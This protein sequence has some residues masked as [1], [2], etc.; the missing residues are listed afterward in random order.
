MIILI[1]S[2]KNKMEERSFYYRYCIIM[3]ISCPKIYQYLEDTLKLYDF[4]VQNF[5]Q[6]KKKYILISQK[7]EQ[8]IL[9][10]AETL[11]IKKPKNKKN[12]ESNNDL[13]ELDQRIIDLEKKEYFKVKDFNEYYPSQSFYDLY[14][15]NNK[16]ESSENNNKRYGLGLFT[17]SEMIYIEK[18]ILENIPI[19]DMKK[20]DELL[21][22]E[23]K[24]DSFIK[25]ILTQELH[26]NLKKKTKKPLIEENSL[27]N[28]LI[29]YK[30]I[31]DHFPLHISNISH[32]LNKKFFS[33]KIPHKLIQNY[34]NDEVAIYFY[35]VDHYT[36]F[37]AIPAILSLF[38]FLFSKFL[39]NKNAE[40]LHIFYAL[41][42]TIWAQFFIIFWNRKESE[43]RVMWDNDSM[44]YEKEDKRKEFVGEIKKSI[45]TG[46]YELYYPEKKK[47]INYAISVF[48][49]LIF[50]SLAV[51][52]NVASL[53]LRNL[54]PEQ[55]IT[56]NKNHHKHYKFMAMPKLQNFR[57]KKLEN[58]T[59]SGLI[60]PIKNILLGILGIIFDK[61]NIFLTDYENHKSKTYYYNSYIYKKFIF[62]SLN[63]FFDIFYIAFALNNLQETTNTIKSLLYLNEIIRILF[64]TVFPFIKNMIFIGTVKDKEVENETRLILGKEIDKKEILKQAKFEK[65]NPFKEYYPLIQEFCFVTLFASCAPLAPILILFTNSFEIKSDFT[66]F[67]FVA[68]RPEPLKKNNIGAWKYIIEFIGIMSIITNILFCY[69]YN[70]NYGDYKYDVFTF[71]IWE[72]FLIGFILVLRLVYP[73][74]TGWV[75]IYRMRKFFRRREDFNKKMELYKDNNKDNIKDNKD[76]K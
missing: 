68:K 5:D 24:K 34:L 32:K 53:N 71:T 27:F 64:E 22:E 1:N 35:W 72:H 15:I 4:D 51:F 46:K 54:I 6:K 28:T 42:M 19:T 69:L 62:E 2:T 20:F 12:I 65:F 57:K 61:V 40:I 23:G 55:D 31:I 45:I 44:E 7:N 47:Y 63:F 67:C 38:I 3:P 33:L 75:K 30:I 52:I 25:K 59:L 43:L 37:I 70:K 10:E 73:N 56:R 36:K 60:I 74:V 50:I 18:S 39:S 21:S 8:R 26:L 11:K 13:L 48:I 9:K 49:T 16:K 41:G 14:D 29:N 17:E 58:K 76:N 66:K